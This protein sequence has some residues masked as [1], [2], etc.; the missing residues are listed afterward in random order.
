[1]KFGRLSEIYHKLERQFEAVQDKKN[2]EM[3]W[4]R[5][6]DYYYEQMETAHAIDSE[7]VKGRMELQTHR[8]ASENKLHSTGQE[9]TPER[10]W[11]FWC[12]AEGMFAIRW[13]RCC[14]LWEV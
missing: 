2:D 9:N 5:K 14:Y 8:E 13:T 3:N 10:G 1:M 7:L 6:V 4:T 12:G 11:L